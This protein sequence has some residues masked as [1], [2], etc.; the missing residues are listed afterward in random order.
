[1]SPTKNSSLSL[2]SQ[3][4]GCSRKTSCS[5][6]QINL[7]QARPRS[8][9]KQRSISMAKKPSYPNKRALP[10]KRKR[11]GATRNGNKAPRDRQIGINPQGGAEKTGS[12]P[13]EGEGTSETAWDCLGLSCNSGIHPGNS[14]PLTASVSQV[15]REVQHERFLRWPSQMKS[16]SATRDD[17]KYCVSHPD[18]RSDPIGGSEPGFEAQDRTGTLYLFFFF[19]NRIKISYT[20]QKNYHRS[21]VHQNLYTITESHLQ[22]QNCTFT[23]TNQSAKPTC[24]E[25]LLVCWPSSM[26]KL[27]GVFSCTCNTPSRESL[28]YMI[29]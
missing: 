2:S 15:P 14:P 9:P 21:G 1:M 4:W 8:S 18:S 6:S 28:Q 25:P 19:F 22:I 16:D 12:S 10:L 26:R 20:Y 13:Q 5:L 7:K 29:L 27:S 3:G 23:F 11:A 24:S 17:T